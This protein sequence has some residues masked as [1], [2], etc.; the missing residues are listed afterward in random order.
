VTDAS[1][2]VQEGPWAKL[3]RR[4]VG[5]WGILYAAGAWGFL[6]GLEYVTDTFHWPDAIQ[7]SATLALLI[8]LPVVLVIAWYHGD[9]GRQRV[10]AAELT[11]ITLLF[12]LGGGIFWLYDRAS[13]TP[14]SATAVPVPPGVE[15]GPS[16]PVSDRSIAVLPFVNMSGDPGNEYF[17]DGISEEILNVLASTPE[18]RVAARTSSFSFKGKAI[19]VPEIADALKVRMVLEGS[20]RRQGDQVRI[21]AQLIDAQDGFH[22]WSQTYDRKLEDIF[23]IQDEIARAIGEELKVKIA[24][25][26]RSGQGPGPPQNLAAHDLYLR[27]MAL[28]HTRGEQELWD[29]IAA[30]EE[31]AALDPESAQ[32][33]GGLALGYAVVGG[34]YS[35]RV[36]VAET[37]ARA[38]DAAEMALALDPMLPE[39]YAAL[40]NA[41]AYDFD[42]RSTSIA[43]LK[44]AIDLRPSFATAHQWLGTRLM[45]SGD[46]AGGLAS[47]ER[48]STLDPRS[49]IIADNH[50]SVLLGLG[51]NDEARARCLE[52]L[53]FAPTFS[54]CLR[55]AG[56]ASLM[57]GDLEAAQPLLERFVSAE[58]PSAGAQATELLDALTGRRDP[59]AF[60]RQLADF[61]INSN[62]DRASGNAFP[63]DLILAIL[64]LLGEREL[65]LDY[66][67]RLAEEPAGFAD[68]AIPWPMMDSIRC[69]PRFMAVVEKLRTIDPHAAKVCAG[70]AQ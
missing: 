45:T 21:T 8:G 27:G 65:A 70:G 39:A 40:G 34:G 2:G 31:A 54:G 37:L 3:R 60:A 36:P 51:R 57:S 11:I 16:L 32:A 23:A 12:L 66:L 20:V 35:A 55:I 69:E 18:L 48:A 1:E 47:L 29:A 33:F 38:R 59:H 13:D 6:Q 44:R 28:W 7:Q 41:A 56:L 15:P 9:Q 10:S 46:L 26:A 58:N 49:P 30:F 64:V 5:Q 53:E 22:V 14:S 17:S 67:E 42:R 19:E 24:G 43:L 68:W 50:A 52:A 63:G 61:P 4:K 25:P 62:L